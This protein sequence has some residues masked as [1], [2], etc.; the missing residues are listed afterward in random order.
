MKLL[1]I[2]FFSILS[3]LKVVI[4]SL[5]I[6]APGSITDHS[7]AL[8]LH[9]FPAHANVR[10]LLIML[11]LSGDISLT[12]GPVNLGFCSKR[13]KGPLISDTIVS[14]RFMPYKL[15]GVP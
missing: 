1:G 15:D 6:Q 9:R 14:N 8:Y 7:K 13:N 12:Q 2:L 3:L 5:A 4:S 10:C 11:L